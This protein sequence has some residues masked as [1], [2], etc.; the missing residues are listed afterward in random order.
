MLELFILSYSNPSSSKYITKIFHCKFFSVVSVFFQKHCPSIGV[1][2]TCIATATAPLF[3]WNR[4]FPSLGEGVTPLS[5]CG[6]QRLAWLAWP[7]NKWLRNNTA[8]RGD[9]KWV[10]FHDYLWIGA[11]SLNQQWQISF[12]FF[13]P[14]SLG[15]IPF[16]NLFFF[17][18]IETTI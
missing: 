10:D 12:L 8:G 13:T 1:H 6:K 16:S 9:I 2:V 5:L 18:W 7:R 3:Y 15:K 4:K 14:L 11:G 17:R